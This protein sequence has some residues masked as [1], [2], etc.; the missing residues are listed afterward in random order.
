[1][2]L[3]LLLKRYKGAEIARRLG[4]ERHKVEEAIQWLLKQAAQ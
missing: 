2:I 1:V 4:L 3:P